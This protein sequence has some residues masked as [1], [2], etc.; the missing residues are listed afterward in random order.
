MVVRGDRTRA[1][2]RRVAARLFAA[3]SYR[4]N[5]L[6]K[7]MQSPQAQPAAPGARTLAGDRDVEWAWS[8]AHLLPTAVRG[9]VLDLGAGHG[10]L[11]LTAAFRGHAVVAVDLEA[12]AFQFEADGIEYLRGDFN[13]LTFESASFDQVINC[14]T[15]EHFGLA[16]RYG[17]I[18]DEDADLVAMGHLADLLR[19]EG[20][21]VLTIP[22]G[23]DGV[24]P[25]YHRVYGEERLPHLLERFTIDHEQYWAKPR[26]NRWDP[27]ERGVAL[28]QQGSTSFYA[29][30]LFVLKPR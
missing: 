26:D 14:S 22:V 11:S 17:S 24:F 6:S 21:M 5:L 15:I 25:P 10:L 30:G 23:R 28:G 13:Q 20:S 1:T 27:V 19:P 2:A 3:G 18:A 16:G 4:L 9:R 8:M 7:R 12:N 29:L